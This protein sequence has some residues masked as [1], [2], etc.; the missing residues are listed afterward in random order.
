[1]ALFT[2]LLNQHRPEALDSGRIVNDMFV[3][4]LGRGQHVLEV[5]RQLLVL[6]KLLGVKVIITNALVANAIHKREG[7][8][9]G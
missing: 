1:V 8:W 7:A 3:D 4:G 6:K 9:C 5:T 2:V